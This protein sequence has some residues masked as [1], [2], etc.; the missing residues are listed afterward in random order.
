MARHGKLESSALARRLSL[1]SL[2]LSPDC[3]KHSIGEAIVV[4]WVG[5]ADEQRYTRTRHVT[6]AELGGLFFSRSTFPSWP[7]EAEAEAEAATDARGDAAPRRDS[8]QPFGPVTSHRGKTGRTDGRTG[9]IP[10]EEVV[11]GIKR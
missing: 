3:G 10:I 4:G 6:R 2:S 8:V 11:D 5:Q 1:L 7:S 9:G